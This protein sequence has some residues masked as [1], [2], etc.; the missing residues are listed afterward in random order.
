MA[1]LQHEQA[2]VNAL[3]PFAA[4]ADPHRIAPPELPITQGSRMARRQLTMADCYGAADAIAAVQAESA[5]R[6]RRRQSAKDHPNS[7]PA[8]P[9][10]DVPS[11]LDTTEKETARA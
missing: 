10:A 6:E 7:T 2:L 9:A 4:F 8:I 11:P 5:A 3:E 1:L